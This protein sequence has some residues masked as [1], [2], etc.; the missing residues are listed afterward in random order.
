MP[1]VEIYTKAFCSFCW[2]AKGLLESKD[3]EFIEIAVDRGGAD[4]ELMIERANGRSSVPQ[5][6]ISGEHVGGCSELFRLE[7]DG[8]LDQ[9]L[10][11]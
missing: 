5:I 7:Q 10:G 2:R 1:L 4:R 3:I 11:A 8:R 9:M 6:F